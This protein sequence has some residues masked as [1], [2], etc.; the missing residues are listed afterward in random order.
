MTGDS[1]QM[2]QDHA[3]SIQMDRWQLGQFRPNGREVTADMKLPVLRVPN[4][5]VLW[6]GEDGLWQVSAVLLQNRGYRK[7][8]VFFLR[9]AEGFFV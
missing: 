9:K 3:E 1:R 2:F 7:D 8:I 5:L 4:A 6:H